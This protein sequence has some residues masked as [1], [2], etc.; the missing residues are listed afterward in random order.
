M[1]SHNSIYIWIA[2]RNHEPNQIPFFNAREQDAGIIELDWIEA[3]DAL[4]YIIERSDKYFP[5]FH[6]LV[7][8]PAKVNNYK[9]S[10]VVKGNTYQYRIKAVGTRMSPYKAVE[11]STSEV[12]SFVDTNKINQFLIYTRILRMEHFG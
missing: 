4:G 12:V 11:I 9:D 7:V 1:H 10:S 8:L 2:D 5:E 3:D 6:R